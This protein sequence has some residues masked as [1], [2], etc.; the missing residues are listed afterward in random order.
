[1]S[2]SST[3]ATESLTAAMVPSRNSALVSGL[4]HKL[5]DKG[6]IS[7]HEFLKIVLYDEEGYYKNSENKVIGQKGDFI[8]SPELTPL[9]ATTIARKIW[10]YH[11]KYHPNHMHLNIIEMGPGYGT[12]IYDIAS[13]LKKEIQNF[14][15]EVNLYCVEASECLAQSQRE[16]LK[17][18]YPN[19]YHLKSLDELSDL[20]TLNNHQSIVTYFIANEYFDALPIQQIVRPSYIPN[21]PLF[22]HFERTVEW[23][24][25]ACQFIFSPISYP[26]EI[27]ETCPAALNDAV[28]IKDWIQRTQGLGIFIDYGYFQNENAGDTLQTVYRHQ[29]IDIFQEL[30]RADISHQVNFLEIAEALAPLSCYLTTQKDFL[31]KNGIIQALETVW[32][33]SPRQEA[34]QHA[35]AVARLIG[36][37]MM[38]S[39][40]VLTCYPENAFI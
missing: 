37:N 26:H 3:A 24:D 12:L 35:I 32:E 40:K 1:M 29:K 13:Y 23:D 20:L 14:E 38:G 17:S 8:T 34:Q 28:V 15:G 21:A 2:Y 5:K 30:G 25:E 27:K 7:V 10:N 9:F 19:C 4:I 36:A 16:R 31:I 18:F 22:E 33:S 39:F 6:T 11:L